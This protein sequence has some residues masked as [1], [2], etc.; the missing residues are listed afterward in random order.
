[1]SV[2]AERTMPAI[3]TASETFDVGLDTGSGVAMEYHDRV[4]FA[5]NGEIKSLNIKYID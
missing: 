5:F 1:M 2:T 4:P 3:F